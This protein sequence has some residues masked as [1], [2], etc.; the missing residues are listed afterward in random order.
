MTKLNYYPEYDY[1]LLVFVNYCY[2][3]DIFA[4]Y[5]FK[6]IGSNLKSQ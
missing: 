3:I 6:Q 5:H 1:G 4:L 2:C